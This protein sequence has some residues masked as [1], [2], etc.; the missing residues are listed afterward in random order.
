[1]RIVKCISVEWNFTEKTQKLVD[2][3]LIEIPKI[4]GLY[5]VKEYIQLDN[6]DNFQNL[7]KGG[8]KE[9]GG[10]VLKEFN[11]SEHKLKVAFNSKNFKI[12][13]DEFTPNINGK[14]ES[15]KMVVNYKPDI[16]F[17]KNIL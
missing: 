11:Y 14:L 2:A 5:E 8:F 12:H 10:Y 17:D 15:F 16:D 1:M 7:V 6:V 9:Y 4:G 3:G 13:K